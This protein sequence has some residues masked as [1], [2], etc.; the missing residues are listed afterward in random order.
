MEGVGPENRD[1]IIPR[2][3]SDGLALMMIRR[4]SLDIVFSL[5][6]SNPHFTDAEIAF[7]HLLSDSFIKYPLVIIILPLCRFP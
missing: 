4:I 1:V 6:D 7:Y 5:S 2:I 3:L